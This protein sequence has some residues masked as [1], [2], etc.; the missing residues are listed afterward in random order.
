MRRRQGF[1]LSSRGCACFGERT[2]DIFLEQHKVSYI[3]RGHEA[4][5]HG[6][7]LSRSGRLCTVFS[8]SKDHFAGDVKTTCGCVLVSR[9]GILPIVRGEVRRPMSI[10]SP[11]P[12]PQHSQHLQHLQQQQQQQ[13]HSVH[14]PLAARGAPMRSMNID[15]NAVPMRKLLAAP[16]DKAAE[17]CE[18]NHN[19]E[20]HLDKH[21]FAC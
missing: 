6:I 3:F 15:M 14:A 10:R 1:G 21:L 17:D 11:S 2:L 7:G 16:R 12:A 8:T 18:G 9:D 4:Q 19:K 5:Q 20:N 13:Q